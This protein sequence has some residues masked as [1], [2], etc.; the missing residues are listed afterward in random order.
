MSAGM[1]GERYFA[2]RGKLAQVMRGIADLAVETGT[3]PGTHLPFAEMAASLGTPFLFVVCGEVN[4]GKSTLINGLCG[5]DLCPGNV[6]PEADRVRSYRFGNPA[7][8]V[9]VAPLLE[10]RYRPLGFLRD[11]QLVDTPGTN[12][13]IQ[14]HQAVT[15]RFLNAADLVLFVFPI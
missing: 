14:G 9:A 7:R 2:M 13:V 1:L 11:F 10:E 3:D 15:E 12:S 4:V 8:D 5:H 6:L